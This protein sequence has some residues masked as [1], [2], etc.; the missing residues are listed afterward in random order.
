MRDHGTGWSETELLMDVMTL[1][2]EWNG[3]SELSFATVNERL[4][5]VSSGELLTLQVVL[6][7]LNALIQTQLAQRG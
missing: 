5:E 3:E 1:Y 6:S 7:M 2:H 4:R